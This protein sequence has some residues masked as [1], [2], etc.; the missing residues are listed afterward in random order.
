M[1]KLNEIFI[2]FF[3]LRQKYSENDEAII[4]YFNDIINVIVYNL[5]WAKIDI[6]VSVLVCDTQISF[7]YEN[8]KKSS[9]QFDCLNR[10]KIHL[11]HLKFKFVLLSGQ[12][13]SIT[14]YYSLYSCYSQL[15]QTIIKKITHEKV[16]YI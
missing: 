5:S 10:M 4:K 8:I 11:L 2:L 13:L 9:I 6:V 3:N 12:L 16:D 7:I 14:T 15:L 1:S